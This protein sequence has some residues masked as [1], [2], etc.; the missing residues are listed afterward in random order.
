MNPIFKQVSFLQGFARGLSEK[1]AAKLGVKEKVGVIKHVEHDGEHCG[2]HIPQW[3][4]EGLVEAGDITNN[5]GSDM[6]RV[7]R[8]ID[9]FDVV[10]TTSYH[11]TYWATLLGKKVI[12]CKAWSSK[13]F[14]LK[15]PPTFYSGNL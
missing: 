9:K 11:A 15:H 4:L 10:V 5:K 12:V 3:T 14:R 1:F 2:Q 6:N 7:I 8:F 13:L